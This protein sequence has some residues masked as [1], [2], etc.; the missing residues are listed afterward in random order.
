MGVPLL[1]IGLSAGKLLPRAGTWMDIVKYVFGVLLLAVAVWMME[2]VLPIYVTMLMWA[3]LLIVS[4]VYMGALDKVEGGGWHKLW[5]GLGF[6]LLVY[7]ILL[8]IGV[9][10]GHYDVFKPLAGLSASAGGETAGATGGGHALDF[11]LVNSLAELDVA[12]EKAAAQNK[13]VMLD[14]YAD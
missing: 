12:V 7:G 4:A 6:L 11:Q 3:T 9:A 8:V 5:K 1:L 14:F 13:P 10:R 2:R